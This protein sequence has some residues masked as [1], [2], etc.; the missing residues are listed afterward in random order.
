MGMSTQSKVID[1]DGNHIT[2]YYFD[3]PMFHEDWHKVEKNE[4]K[5]VA[6]PK[7]Q[8]DNW[9]FCKEKYFLRAVSWY[10][11]IGILEVDILEVDEMVVI[12][13]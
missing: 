5:L 2:V 6:E 1:K 3:N 9:L 8:D 12:K 7:F 10:L 4:L 13:R 11:G